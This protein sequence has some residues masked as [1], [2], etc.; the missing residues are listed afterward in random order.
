MALVNHN[1]LHKIERVMEPL[2][3]TG[4]TPVIPSKS[5]RKIQR[6][7]DKEMYKARHLIE[8]FFCKFKQFRAIVTRYDR[9]K[10]SSPESDRA[11]LAISVRPRLPHLERK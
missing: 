10:T 3:A 7:F 5:S 2:L 4:K 1:A 11:A 6:T 8:N 9:R